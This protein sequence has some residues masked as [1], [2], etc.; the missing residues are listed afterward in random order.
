MIQWSNESKNYLLSLMES[1]LN[2]QS[3]VQPDALDLSLKRVACRA[4][5]DSV[6]SG[7]IT[8]AIRGPSRVFPF[9]SCIQ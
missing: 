6:G 8:D 2:F 1:T 3:N 7:I 5:R 9:L 4:Y